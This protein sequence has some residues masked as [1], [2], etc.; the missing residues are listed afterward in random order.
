LRHGLTPV[1]AC[2]EDVEE[3]SFELVHFGHSAVCTVRGRRS[4]CG[5]K[6]VRL[7]RFSNVTEKYT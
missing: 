3:E 1:D 2:A 7:S 4:K 6:V 5:I